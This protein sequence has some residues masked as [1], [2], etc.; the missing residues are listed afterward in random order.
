M[1]R[2]SLRTTIRR[3]RGSFAV[4][5]AVAAGGVAL[6][7]C[8]FGGGDDADAAADATVPVAT[9]APPATP[10]PAVASTAA[11]TVAVTAP[12]TA[13]PVCV[14]TVE[15]G[16]SLT[17]IADR[18][19]VTTG[20]LELENALDP[21][22]TIHPGQV[23]DICIAN[24]VD[25][26]TGTSRLAP[27]PDAVMRQQAELNELFA[28]TS[29][30]PLGVDGDSGDYTRQAVCAARMGLG[31]RVHAGHLAAGSDEEAAIFAATELSIP[32]GAPTESAKWILVDKTCQVIVIGEGDDRIVDIF[33]TS[34]GEEG[35]ETH[36]IRALAFR[37][38]PATENEGWHDSASYPVAGDNPLNGNMYKPLYFNEGQAIHGAGYIP[39]VPRSKG[40]ARTFP[41]HQDRILEWLGLDELTEATWNTRE[42]GVMVVVQGR[43]LDPTSD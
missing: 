23:F 2:D 37:F 11:T 27:P 35:H 36:D 8:S 39:P 32:A 28:G 38:D 7:G 40:C 5:A 12:T 15:P 1:T 24:D 3:Q 31:L 34:T 13:A 6:A 9:T 4:A 22:A 18:S 20:D 43:Y 30:L 33:P 21:T 19:G 42:I 10:M 17:A 14:V 25:D 16:D 26:V 41:H 29:M